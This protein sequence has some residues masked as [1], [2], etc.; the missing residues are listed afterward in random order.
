MKMNVVQ[1]M[2]FKDISIFSSGGHFIPAVN[3]DRGQYEEHISAHILNLDQWFSICH[4]KIFLFL[5]LVASR[6]V[7]KPPD[8][9]QWPFE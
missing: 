4:L 3:F 7:C 6:A 8:N 9:E 2:S 5:A 1:E